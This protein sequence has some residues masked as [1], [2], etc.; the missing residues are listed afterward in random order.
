M[1]Y[2]ILLQKT[3]RHFLFWKS[4]APQGGNFCPRKVIKH[5][6]GRQR[7]SRGSST[8][9]LYWMHLTL[10]RTSPKLSACLGDIQRHTGYQP[11]DGNYEHSHSKSRRACLGQ[12]CMRLRGCFSKIIFWENFLNKTLFWDAWTDFLAWESWWE[13]IFSPLC[14][15]HQTWCIPK[16]GR[17]NTQIMSI[18]RPISADRFA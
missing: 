5:C 3:I 14:P 10:Y 1:Y 8:G 17:A 15:V 6:C 11:D 12:K 18:S 16:T 2:S 13:D 4:I 7:S 9:L